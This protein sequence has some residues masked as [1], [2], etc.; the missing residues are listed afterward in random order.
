MRFSARAGLVA[1][2]L[3]GATCGTV[4]NAAQADQGSPAGGPDKAVELPRTAAFA[5]QFVND[6]RAPG[7]VIAVGKDDSAP[8]FIA[9]GTL[10]QNGKT[11]VNADSLWRV[12]S[13]TKPVT[14]M[15]AM[16][17]IQDG[18]LK[19]DEPVS[20]F[21]P[22]FKQMQVLDTPDSDSLASHPAKHQITIRMLMT[23][24]AGLGYS[25]ITKGALLKAYEQ[26]GILPGAVNAQVETKMRAV[27]PKS[28]KDFADRVAT[29]PLIAEP[30]TKWSYSIGLDVLARVVEVASGE[31]FEQFVKTRLLTPLKMESTYWTVPEAQVGRL[32]TNY[33]WMGDTMVPMDPAATSVYLQPPSF[34]YGGAGLVMSARDYDRF[35]HMLENGGTLDGVQVMKPETVKLAMS[36]LLP[37]GVT[38]DQVPGGTGGGA[39]APKMGFGAGGS[40][41]LQDVP[42][43]PGKGTY[44][45]GGAAGTIAWVDP[46]HKVRGTVMVNYFPADKW[47]LRQE[48]VKAVYADLAK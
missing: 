16:L 26:K 44:G 7:I 30:G 47:P 42:G 43:G 19:L 1:L 37:P 34:P 27:R 10:A 15:A 4:A 8:T 48:V 39:D 2:M 12:Y 3:A 31:P 36:N 45:W 24:T 33:M 18:K 11:R 40:V 28:L 5:K 14:A 13:M 29:L 32:T 22:G 21:I 46:E 23:H 41:Y 38:F 17:L 6:G 9:D 20:D 35:L 25:I